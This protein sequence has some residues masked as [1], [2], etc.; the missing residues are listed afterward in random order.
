MFGLLLLFCAILFLY[1]F[2][3]LKT[4]I[5]SNFPPG[6]YGWPL[7]GY[8]PVVKD[9]N[10]SN[11]LMELQR[12]YGPVFS[13]NLGPSERYVIIGDH[14]ILEEAFKGYSLTPRPSLIQW[15][16]EYIR[17]GDGHEHSRGLI[18]SKG[19]EWQEQRRF[20]LRNLRDFGFGKSG[21]ESLIKMEVEELLEVMET[22]VG[23]DV[24]FNVNFYASVINA[25]W[26]I[27]NG[28]RVGLNDP[29]LQEVIRYVNDM[30]SQD[31]NSLINVFPAAR[32]ISK[33]WSGFNES[34]KPAYKF[35]AYIKN[36]ISEHKKTHDP[37]SEARDFIDVVLNKIHESQ[38][39]PKSS[40]HGELGLQNLEAGVLD[41]FI[42]GIETTSTALVWSFLILV[43]Y[44]EIQERLYR[45]IQET[46]GSDRLPTMDD[47]PKMP[48]T[49][50]VMQEI[51]R[52]SC[53]APLGIFREADRDMKVGDYYLPK[54]TVVFSHLY[55]IVNDPKVFPNPEKF[56][57][58]RF[59][60]EKGQFKRNDKNIVF[61]TGK[62]DCLGKTLAIAELFLFLTGLIQT[63]QFLP[64]SE[65]SLP[66]LECVYGF[67]RHPQKF[68]LQFKKRTK[69]SAY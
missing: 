49:E 52:F 16:N 27:L 20:T 44:P 58:T 4:K 67:T 23:T 45:E 36:T 60:D 14:D 35:L 32:H 63:Y 43:T 17:Y 25:L 65:G 2:W 24:P 48:F 12:T 37:N 57:P 54:G 10:L 64:S 33:E 15:F 51:L 13:V 62:R 19:E 56:D 11:G 69:S 42:A 50:A 9:S 38:D 3:Y 29:T 31:M 55:A 68:S 34:L 41:L 28:D 30:V 61:S 7:I 5:P 47:K 21:M 40:F 46:V 6:P 26:T 53:I 39:N 1:K 18:F 66:S 22:E 8:Y 59:L